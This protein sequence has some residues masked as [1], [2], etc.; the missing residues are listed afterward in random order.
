M[1]IRADAFHNLIVTVIIMRTR[2]RR[3][4]ANMPA[5][6]ASDESSILSARTKV[7]TT[8]KKCGFYFG[9][10][11]DRNLISEQSELDE[12]SCSAEQ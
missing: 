12:I 11:T 8:S 10:K 9:K 3:I 7:K 1:K 4:M 5:F 2:G 6:Q